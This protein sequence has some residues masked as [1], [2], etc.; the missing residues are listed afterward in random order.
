MGL[1]TVSILGMLGGR[2]WALCDPRPTF[3]S[4]S[5]YGGN[6]RGADLG[7]KSGEGV[8]EGRTGLT[9]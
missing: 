5:Q 1:G 7:A 2:G 9:P 8:S 4:G 3:V 6:A